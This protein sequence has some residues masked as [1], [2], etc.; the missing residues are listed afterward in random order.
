MICIIYISDERTNHWPLISDPM[1]GL[2]IL[3]FY[4]YFSLKWGPRFMADKKPVQMQKTLIIY[5][6][7]QVLVSCYLFHEVC[8]T[9]LLSNILNG[10]EI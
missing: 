9:V 8:N 4:L 7:I 2:T 6:F 1:P 5:N 10:M 3:G